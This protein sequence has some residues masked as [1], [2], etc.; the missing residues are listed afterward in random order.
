MILKLLFI[1]IALALPSG[2]A[3]AVVNIPFSTTY[4]CPEQNQKDTTWVTSGNICDGLRKNGDNTTSA[5]SL[6]QITT[7]ANY[8]GGA[9]GRGQRHWNGPA[10]NN[11][12]GGTYASF[13]SIQPELYIR[14]YQRYQAGF[15]WAPLSYDK[16]WYIQTDVVGKDA[17]VEFTGS[18]GFQAFAQG[19]SGSA[20][21]CTNCGY[22]TIY[23]GGVSDGSW[24]CVEVHIKM[25]TNGA[26]GV[27]EYWLNGVQKYSFNN[28]NFGTRPGWTG[29]IIMSNQADVPSGPDMFVDVDDIRIQTTGPIGCIIVGGDTTPPTITI[30]APT[31]NPTFDNGASATIDLGGTAADNT[32]VA[33]VTW[34]NDRGGSGTASGT[35]SWNIAGISLQ[36]GIN[37]ITVTA[38]DSNNNT[39]TDTISVTRTL[40]SGNILLQEGFNDSN[41]TSRGWYD[42]ATVTISN[43]ES[44]AGG[45]SMEWTW[46]T[47]NTGPTGTLTSRHAFTATETL[48]VRFYQKHSAN[49]VGHGQSFGHH[50]I[51]F[52]TDQDGA[53]SNLAF[54]RLTTYIEKNGGT[55]PSTGSVVQLSIQDGA[56]IDQNQIGVNLIGVTENRGV[57]GCNGDGNDGFSTVT[58]FQG[59]PPTW[60]NGKQWKTATQYFSNT[61]G[62]NYKGD[63]HKIE[64]YFQMNTIVGG[65][66]QP[67]GIMRYWFDGQLVMEHTGIVY[68]T[69][70][71]PTQKWNQVIIAPFMGNG[72]PAAQTMW[73]DEL[74]IMDQAPSTALSMFSRRRSQ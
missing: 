19:G 49:W 6:E 37:A 36:V 38:T 13:S 40:G 11:N 39:G 51:Y 2:T 29:S 57:A 42:G 32:A 64:V 53:F 61:A 52:L 12:S 24:F 9:G 58:C 8:P 3:L 60:W 73:T 70:S 63:W 45:G 66:G 31:S 23:P 68:R 46:T 67:N 56:N 10:N 4:N 5:G 43:A 74:L 35:S 20:H 21:Q 14:W 54:T 15:S 30:S 50:E 1:V 62:P 18:N 33:A 65:V 59:N 47:G 17:I 25:D 69:G 16:L 34:V 27:S 26:N 7:A 22:S 48:Y 72:S 71:R 55:L 44:I 28:V 41:I